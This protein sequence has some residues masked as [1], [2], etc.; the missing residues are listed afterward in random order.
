MS[1]FNDRLPDRP[2]SRDFSHF[3]ALARFLAPY[4]LRIAG[5][6]LA[7]VVAAACVLALGQGLR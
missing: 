1:V 3:M 2:G 7:L 4:R 5:A 6:I